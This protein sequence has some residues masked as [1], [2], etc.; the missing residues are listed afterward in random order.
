M[1]IFMIVALLLLTSCA[2][3]HASPSY[4]SPALRDAETIRSIADDTTSCLAALYPP[5]KTSIR[6]MSL[7]DAFSRALEDNLRNKGFTIA[8]TGGSSSIQVEYNLDQLRLR[9]KSSSWLLRLQ[10]INPAEPARKL[11]RSYSA[12]GQPEAGFSTIGG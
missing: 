1:K 6:L 7:K 9:S 4:V 12:T 5:G 8:G 3:R 11:M 10:I 2:G